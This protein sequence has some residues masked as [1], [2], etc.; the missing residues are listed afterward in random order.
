LF[1]VVAGWLLWRFVRRRAVVDGS[2]ALFGLGLATVSAFMTAAPSLPLWRALLPVLGQ[3]QYPWRFMTLVALGLAIAVGLGAQRLHRA[4]EASGRRRDAES[5]VLAGLGALIALAFITSSLPRVPAEPLQLTSPE[6]WGSARMWADDAAAGQVGA[7]WTGEFLPLTV[8]EQRWALGRPLDG[9]QERGALTPPPDVTLANLGYDRLELSFGGNAPPRVLLHQFHLPAWLA[10][11]DGQPA[12][13]YPSGELGLVTVDLAGGVKSASFRFGPS[14]AVMA[15]SFI[16]VIALIGWV[17]WGWTHRWQAR[18][19][20]FVGL[21]LAAPLLVLLVAVIIANGFGVGV[22]EWTPAPVRATASDLAQLIAYDT[23]PAKGE[24]AL[25][26]TLYWF[27]LRETAQNYKVFVHLL[28]PD[29]QVL[30]QH[31]GDPVGG[32]SPTSRWKQGEL[33]ADTHRLALREAVGPGEYEVRAGMY[34]VRPG[35]TPG[36]R[37]LPVTPAAE[38]ARIV[39]GRVQITR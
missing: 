33:I 28:G 8:R 34:E 15:A 20:D 39:L 30:A 6:A 23:A 7:T 35:E 31:D 19:R 11:V 29:G 17:V 13:T 3:L 2:L 38:D 36:F 14:R 4:G 16:V 9:A 5:Y 26:V 12:E 22:R 27:G 1:L 25:D 24:R 10:W 37:N 18:R 21:T 32:Y